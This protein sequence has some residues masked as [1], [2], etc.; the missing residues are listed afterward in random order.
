M[1]EKYLIVEGYYDKIFYSKL[2]EKIKLKNIKI[3]KPN[4]YLVP[5]NGKGNCIKLLEKLTKQFV[6]G[7]AS[8]IAIILDA[9]FKGISSQGFWNTFHEIEK[10]ISPFG[11]NVKTR[12]CDFNKGIIFNN[13]NGMPDIGVWIMPDNSGE[14]FLEYFILDSLDSEF[15]PELIEAREICSNIKNKK[16]P[17]HH[18]TKAELSIF[19]AMQE[20]PGRNITHIIEKSMLNFNGEKSK[21]FFS[22]LKDYFCS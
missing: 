1:S 12:T 22:F 15:S 17:D 19:M 13:S 5:Y 4:D 20:N 9:D 11:Y 2:F 3:V 18:K 16:F 14:G 10:I 21:L 7:R 6:D 8:K